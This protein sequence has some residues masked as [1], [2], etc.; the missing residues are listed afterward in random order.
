MDRRRATASNARSPLRFGSRIRYSKLTHEE[1]RVC[2]SEAYSLWSQVRI[3][4]PGEQPMSAVIST[5]NDL[6]RRY[7][8]VENVPVAYV[9]VG[10]GDPILFLHG[11]PTPSYLWRHVIPYALPFGRCLAPDYPGMG[12]S[13]PAPDGRYRFFDQRR[14]L[15]AWLDA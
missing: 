1:I 10:E 11:N 12:N 15:D 5:E 7:R 4:S 2:G 8:T 3:T 14:Y 6:Y 13:G 9:D